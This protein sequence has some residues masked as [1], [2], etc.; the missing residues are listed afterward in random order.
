MQLRNT[1]NSAGGRQAALENG[2]K[3]W[4]A[5]AEVRELAREAVAS[6]CVVE[7]ER[8]SSLAGVK[9]AIA[10]IDSAGK[11]ING[12]KPDMERYNDDAKDLC[13]MA[14]VVNR[15]S[16]REEQVRIMNVLR[17]MGPQG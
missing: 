11:A 7:C 13:R 10:R 1:L 4:K 17:K 15:T 9:S 6:V 3:K 2:A 16:I 14:D 12:K 8:P 5:F